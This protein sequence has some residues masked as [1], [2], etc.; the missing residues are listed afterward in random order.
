M[1]FPATHTVTLTMSSPE[2]AK[3][4]A[5]VL[6]VDTEIHPDKAENTI[7]CDCKD[8]TVCVKATDMRVL[9]LKTN[10]LYQSLHVVI[11]CQ[12]ELGCP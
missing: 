5:D 10:A 3:M 11:G 4:A 1:E 7:T 8:L 12:E 6:N 2:M 9:R